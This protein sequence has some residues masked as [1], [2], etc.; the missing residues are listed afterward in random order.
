[1]KFQFQLIFLRSFYYSNPISEN[2]LV[3][4]IVIGQA[5]VSKFEGVYHRVYIKEN[6]M[7][8]CVIIYVDLGITE[9]VKKT[10]MQ[11][12]H[13]LVYFSALPRIAMACR[14]VGVEW[15]LTNYEMSPEIY[16]ELN[17]LCQGGPFYVQLDEHVNDVLNVRIFD[18]DGHCLNDAVVQRGLAVYT[19]IFNNNAMP[20][21]QFSSIMQLNMTIPSTNT[22]QNGKNQQ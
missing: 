5:C 20:M 3:K 17:A 2:S 6:H 7:A 19:L 18:A 9:E 14:L 12:K 21:F 22:I 8:T 15:K 13:L 4:E 10:E 11:F 16:K 1:M